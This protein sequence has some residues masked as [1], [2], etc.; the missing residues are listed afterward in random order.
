MII[1]EW[2]PISG[3]DGYEVSCLGRVRTWR[4][5]GSSVALRDAPVIK[6]QTVDEQGRPR[7]CLS[8]NGRGKSFRACR[9][10]LL[11]FIGEP[12]EGCEACHNDGD[13]TNN[14][15]T[16]LRW[17]THLANM[18]DTIQ[19]GTVYRAL[20]KNNPNVKLTIRDVPEIRKRLDSG[21]TLRSIASDYGVSRK[22]ICNIKHD[23]T[24]GYVSG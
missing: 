2:L 18:R 11:A 19:H 4:K 7:V 24:W 14:V 5:Q 17:D 9:L 16:N 3:F 22:A 13:R 10:V 20:G 23:V 1:E 21:E 12:P 6:K 8:K 15:L